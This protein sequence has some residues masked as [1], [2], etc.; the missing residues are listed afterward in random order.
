MSEIVT[1][2]L[3]MSALKELVPARLSNPDFTV[4][5]AVERQWQINRSLYQLVGERWAWIDKQCWSDRQWESYVICDQLRTFVASQCGL[6]VGYYELRRDDAREVEIAYFGLAP[7][8]IGRGFGGALLTD[9]LRR[10]W[11]WDARRVWVHTCN[12]DHP[13][14][15]QNYKARGMQVYDPRTHQVASS[16]TDNA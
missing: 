5:E 2:Y 13:A 4:R 11:A 8:F 9:A 7:D 14:A 12:L 1:T 15:L 16:E 3:Q 6:T 10:A